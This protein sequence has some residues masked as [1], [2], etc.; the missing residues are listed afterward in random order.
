MGDQKKFYEN[1]FNLLKEYKEYTD[2]SE[3]KANARTFKKKK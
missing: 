1:K 3:N 2:K